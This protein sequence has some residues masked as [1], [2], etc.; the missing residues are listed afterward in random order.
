VP[1][2]F[3]VVGLICCNELNDIPALATSGGVTSR[4]VQ[5]LSLVT[6]KPQLLN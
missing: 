2:I 1:Q 4:L 6:F 5:K 3:I